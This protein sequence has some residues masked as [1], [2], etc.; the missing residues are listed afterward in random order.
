MKKVILASFLLLT[1]CTYSQSYKYKIVTSIESVVPG[2]I[3]RSRIIEN[4]SEIDYTQFTTTRTGEYKN[5]SDKDRSDVK[6]R[7]LKETILVNF[8][9]LVGINLQNI[10]S[11][12]AMITSMLNK[13]SDDG[14]ELI[15]IV[16]GVE[17]DAGKEDGN[18]IFITRFYFKTHK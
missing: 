13:Y 14:W 4:G 9:S 15:N 3:G 7:N 18:G 17:S 10:A 12:D 1:I 8:Y 11:N 2:G 5:K 16:S 6:I